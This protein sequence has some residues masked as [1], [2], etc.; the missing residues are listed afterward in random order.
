MHDS[1]HQIVRTPNNRCPQ[2]PCGSW[3]LKLCTGL[4]NL[5]FRKAN[6]GYTQQDLPDKIKGNQERQVSGKGFLR[7]STTVFLLLR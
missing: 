6:K 4:G 3:F 1:A 7:L 5:T 2:S